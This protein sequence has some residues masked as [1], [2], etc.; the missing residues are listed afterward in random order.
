M[1][2]SEVVQAIEK[3][4]MIDGVI[5]KTAMKLED[6]AEDIL[7]LIES[8]GMLPESYQGCMR[9]GKKYIRELHG[10]YDTVLMRNKWEPEDET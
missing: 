4:L 2:R 7:K 9:D 8:K 6:M 5:M 1:K 10:H 3:Y